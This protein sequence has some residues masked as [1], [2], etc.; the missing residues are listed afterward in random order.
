MIYHRGGE[1][2]Q[3]CIADLMLCHGTQTLGFV[4]CLLFHEHGKQS[5]VQPFLWS[6]K[7]LWLHT[8]SD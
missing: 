4:T 3:A 1:P 7:L 8:R 6:R 2:E 5:F